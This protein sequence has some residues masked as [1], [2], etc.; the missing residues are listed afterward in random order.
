M[1]GGDVNL[2]DRR[3]AKQATATQS[4][5]WAGLRQGVGGR[6]GGRPL[7]EVRPEP[8]F[9]HGQDGGQRRGTVSMEMQEGLSV[10]G[11]P[12]SRASA[13]SGQH[14][15]STGG[16]ELDLCMAKSLVLAPWPQ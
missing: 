1:G 14:P 7:R 11:G 8:G 16:Q 3:A 6:Q 4:P 9:R 13:G 10:G 5:R 12:E 2:A 15:Q